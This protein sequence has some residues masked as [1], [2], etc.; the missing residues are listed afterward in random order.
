MLK[1]NLSLDLRYNRDEIAIE[2]LFKPIISNFLYCQ[3]GSIEE[4]E[5]LQAETY[6]SSYD[7]KNPQIAPMEHIYMSFIGGIKYIEE[8]LDIPISIFI[9]FD[10]RQCPNY[11]NDS[12]RYFS[13]IKIG[14]ISKVY[15]VLF[16]TD[17]FFDFLY[18]K[19]VG[20]NEEVKNNMVLIGSECEVRNNG[21]ILETNLE[22]K[23]IKGYL[24]NH[25]IDKGLSFISCSD[26]SGYPIYHIN[27]PSILE[28]EVGSLLQLEID[29]NHKF[30]KVVAYN[31]LEDKEIQG[32]IQFFDGVL[33][34]RGFNAYIH[35]NINTIFV[36]SDIA[37]DFEQYLDVEVSCL[38]RNKKPIQDNQCDW[39]ALQVNKK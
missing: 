10:K 34:K 22:N 36:P 35:T 27:F 12:N 39:V 20:C 8:E 3:T 2:N 32:L 1:S 15:Y 37:R 13:S 7:F 16:T 38:A 21:K 14:G 31:L 5:I 26:D 19:E 18:S 11:C 30:G 6:I 23:Y 9:T 33:Q 17:E 25:N 4:F 24:N 29:N 28:I